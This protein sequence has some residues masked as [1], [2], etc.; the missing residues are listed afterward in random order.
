MMV[1]SDVLNRHGIALQE[2]ILK[3]R[4]VVCETS[5]QM[6]KDCRL[7]A[8]FDAASIKNPFEII[9]IPTSIKMVKQ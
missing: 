5:P 1:L 7:A 2:T 6:L 3:K 4:I 8:V 9:L